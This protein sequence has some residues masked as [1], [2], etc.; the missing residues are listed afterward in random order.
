M[1]LNVLEVRTINSEST[2][3]AVRASNFRHNAMRTDL[4]TTLWYIRYKNLRNGHFLHF[5]TNI[6]L[7]KMQFAK[8]DPYSAP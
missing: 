5:R 8:G 4:F 6:A 3:E 1:L 7:I 2:T